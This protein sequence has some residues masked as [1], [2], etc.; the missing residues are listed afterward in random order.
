MLY[1]CCELE[2]FIEIVRSK[3]DFS[4]FSKISSF[5]CVL[6]VFPDFECKVLTKLI[7]RLPPYIISGTF[8][9]GKLV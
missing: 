1:F 7:V 2:Y 8:D 5:F 3:F 4:K 9:A 6:E